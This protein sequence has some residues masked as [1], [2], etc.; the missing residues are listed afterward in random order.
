LGEERDKR[1]FPQTGRRWTQIFIFI[2]ECLC[3]VLLPPGLKFPFTI[4]ENGHP[5]A[6]PEFSPPEEKPA[7]SWGEA[8][9]V[10]EWL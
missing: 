2:S 3:I 5:L 8:A 9:G 10:W 1:I 7:A 6:V 4:R